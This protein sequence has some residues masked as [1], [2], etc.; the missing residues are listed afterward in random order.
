MA[1]LEIDWL[2]VGIT[3]VIAPLFYLLLRWLR[4]LLSDHLSY[5]LNYVA[6]YFSRLFHQAL[7]SRL[8]LRRYCRLQLQD[9]ANKKLQ[10]PGKEGVSLETDTIFVP[11]SFEP[12]SGDARGS[13]L[14]E[15]FEKGRRITIVGDP[16]SG[17]SSLVKRTFR[18]AC[19][20]AEFASKEVRL[21]ITVELKRF[22]PPTT[23]SDEGEAGDWAL[24]KLREGIERVQGFDMGQLFDSFVDGQGLL[25]LLDGL[26]EVA[27]DDYR[28]TAMAIRGLSTELTRRS[29]ANVV[30]L[31]MRA[32][33]HQQVRA[34]FDDLFPDVYRIAP[35]SPADIFSFLERW[36]FET[37]QV[38]HVSRIYS[39]L[40][41]RPTLREMCRNPLVLA[42]YVANDQS[43][44]NAPPDTRTSFY[45]QVVD[46]LLVER[47]GRQLGMGARTTLREQ[48]ETILGRLALDNLTDGAQ[49]ANSPTWKAAVEIVM[50][51]H[52]CSTT[53]VAEQL[54]LDLER[55]TGIV[56]HERDGESLRFIHL[57]FCEF[58]AAKE[59][60]L[61]RVDGFAELLGRYEEFQAAD[62]PQLRSRLNEVIPFATALL[63]RVH[64]PA[65]IDE[66]AGACGQE[67]LGRCFLETQAYSGDVWQDYLDQE[68]AELLNSNPEQWTNEW[69]SRLHLFNV[70]LQ[71]A[72]RWSELSGREVGIDLE[73][74]FEHLVGSD[75]QRLVRLFSSY[76][77]NDSAAALRLAEAC[78]VDLAVEEPELV[79][80]NCEFPPFLAVALQRGLA[81]GESGLRWL[82]LLAEAGLRNHFS[83][84]V[85]HGQ[86]APE[87]L[88][89][90]VTAQP[91][92][93]QW[94]PLPH[95][96]V[97]VG[98]RTISV[99]LASRKRGLSA[100]SAILTLALGVPK[101]S[102]SD[103]G[104]L[105]IL[106]RVPP[107]GAAVSSKLIGLLSAATMAGLGYVALAVVPP[108][109]LGVSVLTTS[110][111]AMAGWLLLWYPARRGR[112]YAALANVTFPV[113][114]WERSILL[115]S[116]R[117]RTPLRRR[118]VTTAK[119]T[120]GK[121]YLR[122][123][124][125]ALRD[126]E[127]FRFS[128]GV[129]RPYSR[130]AAARAA[131]AVRLATSEDSA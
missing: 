7:A 8:S 36:P 56:A 23:V 72:E 118:L 105:E 91:R 87:Q 77:L 114:L 131:T 34:D 59:A 29:E 22:T 9:N 112:R 63:P 57:T 130:P 33:F 82:V 27:S 90:R 40:T 125:A 120:V 39:D 15:A 58:L 104:A 55:D 69:L 21:P 11:L 98:P 14:R 52:E 35:F 42:M 89:R 101:E 62:Q 113:S 45:D 43:T 100:Y 70:V 109:G 128:L 93:R 88:R 67:I 38:E 26:D 37:D 6:W 44:I 122:R 25:I 94:A 86:E 121:L 103:L 13:T 107:P 61:G 17:K 12:S 126:L 116:T 108:L 75:R 85:L 19:R 28:R 2:T 60:A 30:V 68:Q 1:A 84:F 76:A 124:N 81:T 54:L 16:G 80:N 20:E 83:A 111:V 99:P 4:D 102:R 10:V 32:Q 97:F 73:E 106:E 129:R 123:L 119:D 50:D 5:V 31:T 96:G 53:D 66:V 48:R 49:A 51:V 3:L 127:E 74:V 117:K 46:E 115:N 18:E 95:G 64:R 110:F 41:D 79:L 71:D 47:R 78:G 65:A 24:A 92:S